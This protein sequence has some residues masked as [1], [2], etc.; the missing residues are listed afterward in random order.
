MVCTVRIE[1][2]VDRHFGDFGTSTAFLAFQI[3]VLMLSDFPSSPYQ[4]VP[5][6]YL[7]IDLFRT[8]IKLLLVIRQ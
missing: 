6:A 7:P 4:P 5:L 2:V 1:L 3:R 8:R